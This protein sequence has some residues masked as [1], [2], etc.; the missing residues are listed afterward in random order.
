MSFSLVKIL[1][2]AI[3]IAERNNN[4]ILTILLK[5]Y[6][7]TKVTKS[8]FIFIMMLAICYRENNI[9]QNDSFYKLLLVY[10]TLYSSSICR[11]L[12]LI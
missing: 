12:I 5:D 2:C 4:K 6:A 3:F 1:S 8:Q 11:T 9:Y 7:K 10:I